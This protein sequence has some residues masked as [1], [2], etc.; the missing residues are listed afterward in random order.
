MSTI[1]T[2]FRY[3]QLVHDGAVTL[4][5]TELAELLVQC[6]HSTGSDDLTV[7]QPG[8]DLWAHLGQADPQLTERALSASWE[9]AP[10]ARLALV[11]LARNL[12]LEINKT[13]GETK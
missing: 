3:G 13:Q 6:V 8:L 1:P 10:D 4:T 5:K 9:D 2:G 11:M 7:P 12:K